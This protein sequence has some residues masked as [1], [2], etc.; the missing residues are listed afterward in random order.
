MSANSSAAADTPALTASA[1]KW[2]G[3]YVEIDADGESWR[4]Y[5]CLRC[6]GNLT[7]PA[8]QEGYGPDCKK[9]RELDWRTT[10]REAL[11]ADRERYRTDR[12]PPQH[13]PK[14]EPVLPRGQ[15]L[16]KSKLKRPSNV[17]WWINAKFDSKCSNCKHRI[18]KGT[19]AAYRKKKKRMLC[20]TCA[21][22]PA[23]PRRIVRSQEIRRTTAA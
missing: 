12:N 7:D 8:N 6:G 23:G 9:R 5:R 11:K 4:F 17:Y 18:A 16:D 1:A 19:K 14:A 13:R 2:R 10:R 21:N 22:G 3:E 15:A 20:V